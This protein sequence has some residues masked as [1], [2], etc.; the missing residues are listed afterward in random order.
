MRPKILFWYEEATVKHDYAWW[1]R[2]ASFHGCEVAV[3]DTLGVF[4]G[5]FASKTFDEALAKYSDHQWVFLHPGAVHYLD[6]Y[7]HPVGPVIY[8]FGSDIHGFGRRIENLPGDK[9]KLRCEE[10]IYALNCVPYVLYD[11]DIYLLRRR[12]L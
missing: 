7:Q 2:Y 12:R 11:R 6:E 3:I 10:E 5:D 4:K 9:I 8:A 1:N